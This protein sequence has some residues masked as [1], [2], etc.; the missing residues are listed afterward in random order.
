L[1]WANRWAALV[2]YQSGIHPIP[3]LEII[4]KTGGTIEFWDFF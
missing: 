4:D 2:M 1:D 3:L